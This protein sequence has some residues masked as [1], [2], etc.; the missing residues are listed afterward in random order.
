MLLLRFHWRGDFSLLG[1][2]FESYFVRCRKCGKGKPKDAF[3]GSIN[4][5]CLDC[6][7][8]HEI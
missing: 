7:G 8:S 2:E 4:R 3:R 5:V 6:R 1:K